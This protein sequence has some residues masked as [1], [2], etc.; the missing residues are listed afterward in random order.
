MG[1]E[2][3]SRLT[4]PPFGYS[5]ELPLRR[6]GGPK[7]RPAPSATSLAS[8]LAPSLPAGVARS[9][10]RLRGLHLRLAICR[11]EVTAG[12]DSRLSQVDD[13]SLIA[14]L[15]DDGSMIVI[16]IHPHGI[17]DDAATAGLAA[18]L[19]H[20]LRHHPVPLG[21]LKITVL[22][23]DAAAI[24]EGEVLLPVLADLPSRPLLAAAGFAGKVPA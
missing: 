22:H 21:A 20:S 23:C 6:P 18:R 10:Q 19:E 12:C 7:T 24:D 17:D 16:F 4:A 5:P 14:E 2:R 11:V 13:R 9:L 1:W 3:G 8:R 15:A